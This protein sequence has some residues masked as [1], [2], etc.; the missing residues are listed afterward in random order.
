MLAVMGKVGMVEAVLSETGLDIVIANQ[1]APNQVV[2]SGDKPDLEKVKGV[3]ETR[4]IRCLSLPVAD[5]F[6]S[7][8]VSHAAD[9]FLSGL[10]KV[11][12]KKGKIPVFLKHHRQK[13]SRS[14]GRRP[15]T[16]CVPACQAG[17]FHVR[18][19]KYVQRGRANLRGGGA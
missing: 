4:N 15:Q 14:P 17:G 9:A 13:I 18:H 1:N 19:R 5:A 8:A 11:S 12:F 6:H 16:S 7:R 3:F 10:E 2:L